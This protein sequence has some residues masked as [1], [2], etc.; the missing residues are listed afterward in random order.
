MTDWNEWARRQAGRPKVVSQEQAPAPAP[1]TQPAQPTLPPPPSG[2]A[3]RLD[4]NQGYVLVPITQATPVVA[5]PPRAAGTVPYGDHPQALAAQR[6]P[7]V[8]LSRPARTCVL[9]KPGNKDTFAEL[10]QGLPDL[11]GGQSAAYEQEALAEIQ[12]MPEANDVASA[13]NPDAPADAGYGARP[14]K[15]AGQIKDL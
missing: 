8:V 3:Y 6:P 1:P 9:V 5:P 7:G 10:L 2:F 11:T 4:A 13:T 12:S 15:G 14:P